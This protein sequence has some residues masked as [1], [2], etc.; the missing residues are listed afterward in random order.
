MSHEISMCLELFFHW[1]FVNVAEEKQRKIEEEAKMMDLRIQ[2][3]SPKVEA[4]VADKYNSIEDLG[5]RAYAILKDL[6][7]I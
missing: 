7:M 1:L 2:P 5:E 3:K 6:G 4:K